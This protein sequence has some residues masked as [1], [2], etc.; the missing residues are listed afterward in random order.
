MELFVKQEL[1]LEEREC[2]QHFYCHLKTRYYQYIIIAD[3][4]L[5]VI[6]HR[7]KGSL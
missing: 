7:K 5:M 6:S 3:L 1:E 4:V 2:D